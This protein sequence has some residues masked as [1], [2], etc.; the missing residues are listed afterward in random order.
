MD[1]I[2]DLLSERFREEPQKVYRW[3]VSEN[4]NFGGSKPLDLISA[5][6]EEKVLRFIENAKEESGGWE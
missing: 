2:I 3:L 1:R 6:R 5:G 4:F